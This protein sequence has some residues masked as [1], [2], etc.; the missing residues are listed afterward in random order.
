MAGN[1]FKHYT[2]RKSLLNCLTVVGNILCSIVRLSCW[3]WWASSHYF[4]FHEF[5][6]FSSWFMNFMF[7][8]RNINHRTSGRALSI[9]HTVMR[10]VLV[11][12]V[13]IV[14]TLSTILI[15]CTVYVNGQER[16]LKTFSKCARM[17]QNTDMSHSMYRVSQKR[18]ICV[19]LAVSTSKLILMNLTVTLLENSGY[20]MHTDF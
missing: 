6:N 16:V 3:M 13:P 4:I 5:F 20:L 18:Q 17:C 14:L 2:C 1:K 8:C 19:I 7:Q 12:L 15:F 11:S 9:R 10:L